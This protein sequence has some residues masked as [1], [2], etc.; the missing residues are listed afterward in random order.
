M[1]KI[2][3]AC[4]ALNAVT[5]ARVDDLGT[6]A[7][8]G[9]G[10][11]LERP[12]ADLNL[13]AWKSFAGEHELKSVN[14]CNAWIWTEG[15]NGAIL[16]ERLGYF[17]TALWI[18]R[19]PLVHAS[20]R[21]EGVLEDDR[22]N[23]SSFGDRPQTFIMEP[24]FPLVT[25]TLTEAACI[26]D[27]LAQ[28]F[29]F[30]RLAG[31][32]ERAFISLVLAMHIEHIE[33]QILHLMRALEGMLHADNSRQFAGRAAC[34]LKDPRP[35]LLRELYHVR[36]KLTHAEPVELA[37]P[38]MTPAQASKRACQLRAFLYHLATRSYRKIL[39]KPETLKVLTQDQVG[40]FWGEVVLGREAPPFT[41]E[42]EDSLWDFDHELGHYLNEPVRTQSRTA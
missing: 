31:R 12:S 9:C 41:V 36:N 33:D 22:P 21:L 30:K 4:L 13:N 1:T 29:Q 32:L 37:F 35:D 6:R 8:L 38:N 27:T 11:R 16:R 17:E 14:G 23:V 2:P 15:S 5:D 7:D 25:T 20:W 3:F 28:T 26:A 42:V 10:Y 34:I 24:A 18:A 40:A 39:R 19:A